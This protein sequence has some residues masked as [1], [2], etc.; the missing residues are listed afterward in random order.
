MGEEFSWGRNIGDTHCPGVPA[1]LWLH[2][3]ASSSTRAPV[4]Q[5]PRATHWRQ[6]N[7]RHNL[8]N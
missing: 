7:E 3:A 1:S 5:W 2:V 4:S 8:H 6:T